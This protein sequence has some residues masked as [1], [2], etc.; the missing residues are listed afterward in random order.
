MKIF[1]LFIQE[2]AERKREER[3]KA[4][5]QELWNS[6]NYQSSRVSISDDEDEEDVSE[7]AEGI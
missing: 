3:R 5:L 6:K 4:K 1:I 2:E 7:D